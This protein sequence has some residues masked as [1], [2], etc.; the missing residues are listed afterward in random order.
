MPSF[1]SNP[2]WYES[3]LAVLL[4]A[5]TIVGYLLRAFVV[6]PL[7]NADKD[8]RERLETIE[9]AVMQTNSELKGMRIAQEGHSE[10]LKSAHKRIDES[11]DR[12][13]RLEDKVFFSK[14]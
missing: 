7:L 2:D 13:K 12:I 11:Q 10:S 9:K 6:S 5:L 3:T 4:A 8:N 1:L 14:G